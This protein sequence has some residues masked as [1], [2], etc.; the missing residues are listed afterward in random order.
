MKVK[1]NH[2]M[3]PVKDL[4]ESLTGQDRMDLIESLACESDVIMAVADLIVDGYT[5]NGSAPGSWPLRLR[6]QPQTPLECVRMY[7]A[8]R[9]SA[10]AG[11]VFAEVKASEERHA[12]NFR[13]LGEKHE[14]LQREFDNYKEDAEKDQR[15]KM[16]R[17]NRLV[18]AIQEGIEK[19]SAVKDEYIFPKDLVI[20]ALKQIKGYE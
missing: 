13:T 2:L 8:N 5:A 10:V 14:R 6:S 16:Y 9:Y 17:I 12:N 1:D 20:D 18:N 11:E 15:N 19:F 3:I 7:I 4:L